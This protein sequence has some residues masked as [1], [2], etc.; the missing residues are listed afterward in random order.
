MYTQ[1]NQ[2]FKQAFTI[3]QQHFINLKFQTWPTWK[4]RHIYRLHAF[5]T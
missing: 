4:F 5:D 3:L 1:F 2:N